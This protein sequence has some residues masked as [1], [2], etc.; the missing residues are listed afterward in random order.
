MVG[1]FDAC[2]TT[3]PDLWRRVQS[4]TDPGRRF[5]IADPIHPIH[6]LDLLCDA[7]TGHK[8]CRERY[9]GEIDG[10]RIVDDASRA[11]WGRDPTIGT[12]VGVEP[13]DRGCRV[14]DCP[15][16]SMAPKTGGLLMWEAEICLRHLQTMT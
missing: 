13:R 4:G 14:L 9:I 10:Q 6:N 16:R 1:D 12:A 3:G 7:P 15:L 8:G 5:V 11:G 2:I